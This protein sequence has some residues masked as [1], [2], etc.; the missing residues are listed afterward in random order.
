MIVFFTKLVTSWGGSNKVELEL[1]L[2]YCKLL[3]FD[4]QNFQL[5]MIPHCHIAAIYHHIA[6]AGVHQLIRATRRHR[7]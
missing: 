6:Q 1:E 7:G 4:H 2:E 3:L 5:K